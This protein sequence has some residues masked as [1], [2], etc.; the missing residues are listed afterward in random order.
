[1]EKLRLTARVASKLLHV[2]GK[3]Y[4]PDPEIPL[5]LLVC[6]TVSR[7]MML[8]RGIFGLGRLVFL[9]RSVRIRGRRLLKIG[10][11]ATI[12][13]NVMLDAYAR[14]GVIVG[15]GSRIGAHSTI[16]STAHLSVVGEGL[17]MG[18][19]SGLGEY[20]YLGCAGGIRIGDHVIM[21]QYV[22]FHAQE[23][24][25]ADPER[26]IRE[27]GVRQQG[28]SIGSDCW[29]GARATF[30]DGTEVGSHSVVAAGAVVRGKFPAGAVIG[31]VPA[32]LLKMRPGFETQQ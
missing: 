15:E 21:G 9:G 20:C 24:N 26:P 1:M 32:R 19:N 18:S 6:E 7:F 28:I 25:F 31:G 30:L 2:M 12:E 22:S 29:V 16:R 23:H 14:R 3:T 8:V 5:G 4:T 13:D 17:I 10:R 27:Q 11:F